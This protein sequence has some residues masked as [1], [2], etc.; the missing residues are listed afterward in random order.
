M[1]TGKILLFYKYIS[2][3]Y[4]KQILKWQERLCTELGLK[5][6]IILAHEGINATLGGEAA[7]INRYKA[8]MEKHPLFDSIDFKESDGAADYF[9]R[10][11]VVIKNEIVHLGLDPALVKAENG[12]THLSP[13][14]AHQMMQEKAENLV[15]LDCRNTYET[16]IGTFIDAVR[17]DTKYFREFPGYVDTNADIFKGKQVLMAC[18]GGIRCER[19]SAYLKSKDIADQVYQIE[20]GIHR[21]VEQFP[22]G[23]FRGKN[24]VFDAR[25]AVPVNNDVLGQC[26]LCQVAHDEYANCLNAS[27]NKHFICCPACLETYKN[28]CST[29]C[30]ELLAANKVAMRPPRIKIEETPQESCN[31]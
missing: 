20:G 7:N 3:E 22:N 11:R 10:L 19:A 23:F 8:A 14:Q 1:N 16:T 15:I 26:A 21:Y 9:P 17:P 24:Y 31:L 2:I 28:S 12:G 6:R 13:A 5:G 29:L 4:P 18:T 27:C 25:V 30:L